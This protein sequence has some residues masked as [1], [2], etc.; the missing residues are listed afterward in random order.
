MTDD[1]KQRETQAMVAR[2]LQQASAAERHIYVARSNYGDNLPHLSWLADQPDLDLAT[3]VMMFWCLG[4][5]WHAGVAADEPQAQQ[6]DWQLTQLLQQR[7]AQGFY[8]QGAIHF[9]PAQD[10]PVS[11]SEYDNL[12]VLTPIDARMYQVVPGAEPV[13][14]WDESFDD[15]LPMPVVEALYALWDNPD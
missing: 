5:R 3:A 9:D 14:V 6:A 8:A 4:G 2:H 1:E 13:D 7:C 15:G 12:P 10:S 11:P